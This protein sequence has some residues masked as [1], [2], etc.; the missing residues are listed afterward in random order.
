MGRTSLVLTCTPKVSIISLFSLSPGPMCLSEKSSCRGKRRSIW[1]WLPEDEAR[2]AGPILV[3]L[4]LRT[5]SICLQGALLLPPIALPCSL[6]DLHSTDQDL[7][8]LCM[9]SAIELYSERE[10]AE[11]H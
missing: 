11:Q 9:V 10:K 3:L 2:A 5:P 8:Q 4:F 6:T 1:R 7:A